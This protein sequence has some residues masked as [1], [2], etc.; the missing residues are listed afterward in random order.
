MCEA[1]LGIRFAAGG[2]A[3]LEEV[4]CAYGE[5]LLRYATSMLKSHHDA[6]DVLQGVFH[7]AYQKRQTF[8]GQNLSAWLYKITYRH[9][10]DQ[11]KKR[12]LLFFADLSNVKEEAVDPFADASAGDEILNALGR[13]TARERALLFGRIMDG[14]SYEELAEIHGRSSAALRK[15]YERTKKKLAGHLAAQGMQGKEPKSAHG[16]E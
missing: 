7:A 4:V 10:L 2:E 3:E 6:E 8:D 1:D 11:L 13:L 15:Q 16:T 14:H 5:K 12:K 9:C